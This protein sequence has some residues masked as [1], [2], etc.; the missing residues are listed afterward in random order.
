MLT[1]TPWPSSGS[2]PNPLPLCTILAF[3]VSNFLSTIWR[4]MIITTTTTMMTL[5][6][7][8]LFV[9]FLFISLFIFT[10][11]PY[12]IPI[13]P[14]Y[15]PTYPIRR[16]FSSSLY[17]GHFPFSTYLTMYLSHLITYLPYT[18]SL[19]AFFVHRSL[20][21]LSTYFCTHLSYYVPNV[22]T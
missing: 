17:I 2:H 6:C 8:C 11:L 22:P 19:P 15:L 4:A 14:T 20:S 7:F 3:V 10:C 5:F 18:S 12:Y 1:C 21:F 16:L 13:V 9:F